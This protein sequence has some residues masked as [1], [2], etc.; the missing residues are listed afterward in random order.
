MGSRSGM[1]RLAHRKSR[2]GVRKSNLTSLEAVSKAPLLLFFVFA[3]RWKTE[4]VRPTRRYLIIHPLGRILAVEPAV[5]RAGEST[6]LY[7]EWK[8]VVGARIR[9]YT[10]GHGSLMHL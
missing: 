5:S 6:D 10:P 4:G 8:A 3:F 1:E 2:S 7:G 9:G